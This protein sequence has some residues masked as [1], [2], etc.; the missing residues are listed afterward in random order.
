MTQ[1]NRRRQRRRGGIGSK[2]L[3]VGAGVIAL[4]AIAVIGVTSWVLDVAADAP[5]LATCKPIDR[6]GNSVL[7]DAAGDK[8]GVIASDEA[9]TPVAIERIPKSLQLAT[10]AIEDQRFY[11]HGGVDAEG[12]GR[13]ALKDFEAGEAVEGVSTIT[14]QLVRN[15]CIQNPERSLKRKIVEAKLAEEYFDRHT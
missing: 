4:I 10:V 5:S 13:A 1:R 8:L 12:I 2:L 15:L 9:R 7:Y 3:I 11:E 6:G 14:Q